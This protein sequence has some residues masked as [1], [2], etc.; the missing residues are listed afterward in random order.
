M[1]SERYSA[2][3]LLPVSL[4]KAFVTIISHGNSAW[5]L[6]RNGLGKQTG[7]FVLLICGLT[8]ETV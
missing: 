2:L 5:G 6:N 3:H 7:D 8:R 4:K 1:I